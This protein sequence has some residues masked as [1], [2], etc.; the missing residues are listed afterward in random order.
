[1]PWQVVWPMQQ[2][3]AVIF[4]LSVN[5][6]SIHFLLL[7]RFVVVFPHFPLMRKNYAIWQHMWLATEREREKGRGRGRGSSAAEE[8]VFGQ[9]TLFTRKFN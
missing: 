8:V 1:M 6:F 9:L 5:D 7:R 2:A 3:F 4:C